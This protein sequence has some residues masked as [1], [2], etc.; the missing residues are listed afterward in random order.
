MAL[1]SEPSDTFFCDVGC[2]MYCLNET[3]ANEVHKLSKPRTDPAGRNKMQTFL[4]ALSADLT[5][6]TMKERGPLLY[7]LFA[8][9]IL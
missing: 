7:I 4:S 6:H 2:K 3:W 5:E 1:Y 9:R 8:D